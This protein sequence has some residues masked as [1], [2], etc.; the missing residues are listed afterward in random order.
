MKKSPALA[1]RS[2]CQGA[3][4]HGCGPDGTDQCMKENGSVRQSK[5]AHFSQRKSTLTPFRP[6]G[7]HRG[8]TR[9]S[10]RRGSRSGSG[11]PCGEPPRASTSP[12]ARRPGASQCGKQKSQVPAGS[13]RPAGSW[14]R[15]ATRVACNFE[16]GDSHARIRTRTVLNTKT[17]RVPVRIPFRLTPKAC[18]I[19]ATPAAP[20]MRKRPRPTIAEV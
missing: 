4:L 11:A 1:H 13:W 16:A 12:R 15:M 7:S 6:A 14:V 19:D 8:R 3:A 2:T 9:V 20:T 10:A 17:G 5:S 18:C